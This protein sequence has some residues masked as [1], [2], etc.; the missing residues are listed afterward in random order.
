MLAPHKLSSLG[1]L[2]MNVWPKQNS[3]AINIDGISDIFDID[4][5]QQISEQVFM[6]I[7]SPAVTGSM[8]GVWIIRSVGLCS[9]RAVSF[10][11]DWYFCLSTSLCKYNW[12][13]KHCQSFPHSWWSDNSHMKG[14]YSGQ[15]PIR[16][17]RERSAFSVLFLVS[18][19]TLKV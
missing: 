12:N 10:S 13:L 8:T 3:A 7:T 18:V 15:V 1:A 14:W 6:F 4:F 17:C 16:A 2:Q 11:S 5:F 9:N 19:I